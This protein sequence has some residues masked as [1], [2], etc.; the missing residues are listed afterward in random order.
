MIMTTLVS[1][2]MSW[3]M[4][5]H[6]IRTNSERILTKLIELGKGKRRKE[7]DAEKHGQTESKN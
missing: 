3:Y 4:L 6:I 2:Q 1:K 5:V 7:V